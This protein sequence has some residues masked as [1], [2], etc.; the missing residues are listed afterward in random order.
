MVP[1]AFLDALPLV[2]LVTI[3]TLEGLISFCGSVS[4]ASTAIVTGVFVVVDAL[5]FCAFGD[6]LPVDPTVTVTLAVSQLFAVSHT[7]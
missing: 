2:G 1:E 6:V 7:R 4:L 3:V 5:S